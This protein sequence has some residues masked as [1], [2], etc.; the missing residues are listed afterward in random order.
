VRSTPPRTFNFRQK[1]V[2]LALETRSIPRQIVY[3]ALA[4]LAVLG[5]LHLLVRYGL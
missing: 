2:H 1:E 3:F 4:F 5:I